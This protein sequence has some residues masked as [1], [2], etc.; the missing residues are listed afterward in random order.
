MRPAL[1]PRR[2]SPPP[3]LDILAHIDEQCDKKSV[4]ISAV[5]DTHDD[6]K[7]SETT[8]PSGIRKKR[9]GLLLVVRS[10]FSSAPSTRGATTRKR[11]CARSDGFS[12]RARSQVGVG[13]A[14]RRDK[15]L[16]TALQGSIKRVTRCPKGVARRLRHFQESCTGMRHVRTKPWYDLPIFRGCTFSR[17][18]SVSQLSVA[19]PRYSPHGESPSAL[20]KPWHENWAVI[21][22]FGVKARGIGFG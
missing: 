8:A 12:E 19:W 22:E 9:A 3:G 7:C 2:V 6:G 21:A 10:C 18:C 17:L 15:P 4:N 16:H 13:H 11:E 1:S 20:P 14:E 5:E